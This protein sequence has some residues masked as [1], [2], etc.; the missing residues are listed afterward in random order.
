MNLTR[1]QF[2]ALGAAAAASC[3]LRDD[4][5]AAG[6]TPPA[7]QPSLP[8]GAVDAGPL[9]DFKANDAY[10]AFRQQGFFVIRRGD[11]V[12]AL[13]SVCTHKGCKVRVQD[14]LSFLCKCHGSRFDPDGHVTMGPATRDLPRLA[15]ALALD[16]HVIVNLE[17]KLQTSSEKG[18]EHNSER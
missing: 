4:E 8:P 11:E 7:S 17:R 3:V 5:A 12:F 18:G 13:S 16:D 6:T 2:A 1:R 15:V 14:D 9:G 10:D